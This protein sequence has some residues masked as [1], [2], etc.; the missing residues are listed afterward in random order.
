MDGLKVTAMVLALWGFGSYTYPHYLEYR[1]LK[2]NGSEGMSTKK[3]ELL[4]TRS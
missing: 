1:Q 4:V 2:S 3:M